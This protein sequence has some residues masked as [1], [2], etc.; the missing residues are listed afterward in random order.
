MTRAPIVRLQD[1]LRT[2]LS[3]QDG[4]SK[5]E[6]LCMNCLKPGHFVKQCT[7]KQAGKKC[8]QTHHT[9]LYQERKKDNGV[10]GK[11]TPDPYSAPGP[12]AS[13]VEFVGSTQAV[14]VGGQDQVL[15]M[16][17]QVMVTRPGGFSCRARALLDT[18]SSLSFTTECLVQRL[19]LLW[20]YRNKQISGIGGTLASV[21]THGLYV[22]GPE[23]DWPFVRSLVG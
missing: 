9:L 2:T 19:R 6:Q 8:Q 14:H 5:R 4:V 21:S 22:F 3:P 18:G 15:L 12:S 1:I 13:Q 20:K 11:E 7:S 23:L 10:S 17:C 16:T